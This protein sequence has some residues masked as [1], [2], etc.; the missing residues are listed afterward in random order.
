MGTALVEWLSMPPGIKKFYSVSKLDWTFLKIL[1]L[2]VLKLQLGQV[3]SYLTSL[4]VE[5]LAM[6]KVV[7]DS[8]SSTAAAASYESDFL[9]AFTV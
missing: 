9:C 2:E 1:V 8:Q 5:G 4:H 3:T 6:T 7:E